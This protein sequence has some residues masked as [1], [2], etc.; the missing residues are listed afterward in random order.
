MS[1]PPPGEHLPQRLC[2]GH[3][4]SP[5]ARLPRA[6]RD[7]A[8]AEAVESGVFLGLPRFPSRQ[9]CALCHRSTCRRGSRPT[10]TA[11]DR[12][13]ADL[14][15]CR[16]RGQS[17][18]R[19]AGDGR[20]S[21][22][23]DPA[24]GPEAVRGQSCP[25]DGADQR[26]PQVPSSLTPGEIDNPVHRPAD[27]KDERHPPGP[28]PDTHGSA[29]A[30]FLGVPFVLPQSCAI[31]TY[32]PTPCPSLASR[33]L[34]DDRKR[35]VHPASELHK[36]GLGRGW[37]AVGNLDPVGARVPAIAEGASQLRPRR[38]P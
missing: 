28:S 38:S 23:P 13:R 36:G 3:R 1:R 19:A 8:P 35:T 21:R 25:D 26:P 27:R 10:P 24:V 33:P 6:G 4:R 12:K 34:R 18:R 30:R 14:G 20:P 16:A 32:A 29:G 17:G 9:V 5:P 37:L 11:G 31:H 15:R 7:G 22:C 2:K